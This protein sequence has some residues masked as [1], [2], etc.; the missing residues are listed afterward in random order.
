MY[1]KPLSA[2]TRPVPKSHAFVVQLGPTVQRN[3]GSPDP[4]FRCTAGPNCT[5]K[6]WVLNMCT[7]KPVSAHTPPFV[8]HIPKTQGFVVQLGPTV[9]RNSG[10][11]DP[12]FRC[13]VGPNCTTKP[14]VLNMCTT[15]PVSAHTPPF[16]VHMPKTQGFVVQL[17]PTVQRNSGSPD[18]G[19]RCTVG[20]NCTTEPPFPD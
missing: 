3:S 12:G 11:P 6:P 4:G 16:V 1:V 2:H 10:S 7:T 20:P 8:V 19:F 15:K 17:G 9:Q 14:W 13:T 18:P 5:T